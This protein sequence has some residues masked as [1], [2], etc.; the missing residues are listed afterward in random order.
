MAGAALK[1]AP[2]EDGTNQSENDRSI[3][4]SESGISSRS[5]QGTA[6]V[7]K[8][9]QRRPTETTLNNLS[10][11]NNAL[12][13]DAAQNL[14]ADYEASQSRMQALSQLG[15]KKSEEVKRPTPEKDTALLAGTSNLESSVPNTIEVGPSMEAGLPSE[16][17]CLTYRTCYGGDT[18]DAFAPLAQYTQ[19]HHGGNVDST[20]NQFVGA[21]ISSSGA[22]MQRVRI[23]EEDF[24]P[25][26]A[27]LM[28]VKQEDDPLKRREQFTTNL[29]KSKK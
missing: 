24:V 6:R 12:S 21:I 25:E 18:M 4:G 13:K 11:L 20:S 29:R 15:K 9:T 14:R 3:C 23:K 19:R 16:A 26:S 8:V 22:V 27:G 2:A 5:N 7:S 17:E 28:K 1:M 10:R